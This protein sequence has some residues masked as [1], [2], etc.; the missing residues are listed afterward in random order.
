MT[1]EIDVREPDQLAGVPLPESRTLTIGHAAARASVMAALDN[2]RLPGG[3]LL[4]GPRGI[5]KATLAFEATRLCRARR[6]QVPPRQ[7][8]HELPP[9]TRA[10]PC[11]AGM[12]L[13]SGSSRS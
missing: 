6:G 4:H 12:A 1:D 2:S 11:R 5:G 3:I 13:T 10:Y 7:A 8:V 9:A